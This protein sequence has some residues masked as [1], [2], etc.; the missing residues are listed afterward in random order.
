[1]SNHKAK[2]NVPHQ[3]Q[4]K[5]KDDP[6]PDTH[7][8]EKDDPKPDTHRK[9]KVDTKPDPPRKEKV[10]VKSNTN[11]KV[12][13][14]LNTKP[15]KNSDTNRKEKPDTK[16][17]AE[18]N[19]KL[20]P[21]TV[22]IL[23][24][25]DPHYMKGNKDDTNILEDEFIRQVK[26]HKPDIVAVMGDVLDRF[27]NVYTPV[28]ARA[29]YFLQELSELA[30]L[31][32]LVGNHDRVNPSDYMSDIHAF[33]ACH[34]WK[35][36]YIADKVEKVTIKGFNFCLVPYVPKNRYFEALND[37]K[38]NVHDFDCFLSHQEFQGCR[39]GS[40]ESPESDAK[41]VWDKSFPLNL[42]GHI[43]EYQ[44]MGNLINVGTAYM[45][46]FGEKEEKSISMITLTKENGKTTFEENRLK[47]RTSLK[48]TY[49]VYAEDYLSWKPP[50]TLKEMKKQNIRILLKVKGSKEELAPLKQNLSQKKKLREQYVYVSF[51][52][53][54]GLPTNLE[55]IAKL[56]LKTNYRDFKNIMFEAVK[57]QKDSELK[58]VF[59][60][61]VSLI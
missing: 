50:Y 30:T 43:H 61:V 24:L 35:N 12:N 54:R 37:Y 23:C 6:K 26:K 3:D 18:S 17:N 59:D 58:E 29:L 55:Y 52:E 7:R 46:N 48:E 2:T 42:N 19:K 31:F 32:V 13:T 21:K 38:V 8:K 20:N 10:D 16:L 4:V 34:W 22:K 25:G 40:G 53:K 47:I 57:A 41:D 51:H 56:K 28:L 36:T 1:M 44:N 27:G 49:K 45:V 39:Y 9:E 14:E 5:E 33:I 60:E 11:C 15:N